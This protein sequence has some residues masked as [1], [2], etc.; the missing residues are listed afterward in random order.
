MAH[1]DVGDVCWKW[2]V[3][4]TNLRCCSPFRCVQVPMTKT[5]VW[6]EFFSV[7]TLDLC[8]E[9][10]DHYCVTNSN[11]WLPILNV[12]IMHVGIS[13]MIIFS[14]MNHHWWL[15]NFARIATYLLSEMLSWCKRTN[16]HKLNYLANKFSFRADLFFQGRSNDFGVM[17][18]W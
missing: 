6:K 4:S 10:S 3:L 2:Y 18:L 1:I 14:V 9:P 15:H 5:N 16:C 7:N 17:T 13:E 12:A 11:H 8:D